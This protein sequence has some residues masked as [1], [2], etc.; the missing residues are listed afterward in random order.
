MTFVAYHISC[1]VLLKYLRLWCISVIILVL[2]EVVSANPSHDS[3]YAPSARIFHYLESTTLSV[4]LFCTDMRLRTAI[5]LD[6]R[7]QPHVY[8]ITPPSAIVVRLGM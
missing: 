7:H 4:A 8:L 5:T 6:Q 1:I 2:N 3:S